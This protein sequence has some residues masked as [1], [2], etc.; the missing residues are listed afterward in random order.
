MNY[1][2]EF[3]ILQLFHHT[4]ILITLQ[5][6]IACALDALSCVESGDESVLDIITR[7]AFPLGENDSMSSVSSSN[8]SLSSYDDAD[9][10]IAAKKARLSDDE[11]D[12][13]EGMKD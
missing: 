2:F 4:I 3:Y 12:I 1:I 5:A 13:S 9:C 7:A 8:S 11:N 6:D 10:E